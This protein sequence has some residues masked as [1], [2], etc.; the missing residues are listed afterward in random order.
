MIII[1]TVITTVVAVRCCFLC[2]CFGQAPLS[3]NRT[4]GPST[5]MLMMM[6]VV[7]VV[8]DADDDHPARVQMYTQHGGFDG[9]GD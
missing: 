9:G 6:V 8:T 4:H 7:V 1:M 5:A 3:P 2:H